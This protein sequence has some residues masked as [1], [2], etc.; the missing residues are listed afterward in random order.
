M[1][2]NLP[3]KPSRRLMSKT[4]DH[5]SP[6]GH[7]A[8]TPSDVAIGTPF[9]NAIASPNGVPSPLSS[10]LRKKTSAERARMFLEGNHEQLIASM[11]SDEQV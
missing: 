10:A 9:A 2:W 6:F 11:S 3:Y 4:F 8:P 1:T 7:S 5:S